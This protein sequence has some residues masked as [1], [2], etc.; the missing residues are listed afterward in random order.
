MSTTDDLAGVLDIILVDCDGDDEEYSA[1]L[2]LLDEEIGVPMAASLLGTP[3]CTSSAP[4]SSWQISRDDG[5]ELMPDYL[6]PPTPPASCPSTTRTRTPGRWNR[7]VCL[8]AARRTG[9]ELAMTGSGSDAA[10]IPRRCFMP[11]E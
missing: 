2:I 4:S 11:S 1:F 3:G 10:A 9:G 8:G 6:R 7:A 5:Q